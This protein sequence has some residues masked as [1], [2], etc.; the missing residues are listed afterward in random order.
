MKTYFRRNPINK[1]NKVY[2]VVVKNTF[3]HGQ[4]I[5]LKLSNTEKLENCNIIL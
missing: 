5:Q 4:T 2:N 3:L 1:T